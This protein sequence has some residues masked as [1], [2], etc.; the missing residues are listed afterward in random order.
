MIMRRLLMLACGMVTVFKRRESE[1]ALEK[2]REMGRFLKTQVIRHFTNTEI[3]VVQQ[4][5][6][7][8]QHTLCDQLIRLS[9]DLV[10][11]RL[12]QMIG[13]DMLEGCIRL[14]GTQREAMLLK[15]P[16]E[17]RCK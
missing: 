8:K 10:G 3:S 6:C 9:R 7:L 16:Q 12:T 13:C 11:D 5:L 4:F 15:C 14:N 2:P 1:F 17:L